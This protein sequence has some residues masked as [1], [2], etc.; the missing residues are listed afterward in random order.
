M[1]ARK[2]TRSDDGHI[3]QMLHLRDHEG[4]TAYAIGKRCGTSRG[5]VAGRFKR[6]RDDEQPCACIKPEN[7]D[8]ALPP[9]W[10]KA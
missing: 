7:K 9:R 4:M 2:A 1:P 10:W 3:L 5:G 6:I 8:G